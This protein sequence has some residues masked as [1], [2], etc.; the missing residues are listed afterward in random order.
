MI[1]A[2]GVTRRFEREDGHVVEALRG[3]DLEVADGELFALIGPDG[4]GK[5]TFFRIVA[6]LLAPTSGSVRIAEGTT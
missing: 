3:V 4:A 1:S 2:R 6:G 5:T